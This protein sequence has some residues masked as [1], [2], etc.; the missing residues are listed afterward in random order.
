MQTNHL[1][2]SLCLWN[3]CCD[4]ERIQ[5]KSLSPFCRPQRRPKLIGCV[6]IT[7]NENRRRKNSFIY[8]RHNS[9]FKGFRRFRFWSFSTHNFPDSH[10]L[11]RIIWLQVDDQCSRPSTVNA[12]HERTIHFGRCRRISRILNFIIEECVSVKTE[13]TGR[14]ENWFHQLNNL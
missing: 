13:E 14:P 5:K 3:L 4:N 7:Q 6:T 1:V 12:I 10:E 2:R 8:F 11:K 9:F